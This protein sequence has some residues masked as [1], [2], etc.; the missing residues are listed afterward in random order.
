MRVI[1]FLLVCLAFVVLGGC[2]TQGAKTASGLRATN[3]I[4]SFQQGDLRLHC[5]VACSGA[6]GWSR[7]DLK[8]F[9]RKGL[10]N[11]LV[12]SIAEYGFSVD[13]ASFYLAEAAQQTGYLRAAKVY[14]QLALSPGYRCMGLFNNCDGIDVQRLSQEGLSRLKQIETETAVERTSTSPLAQAPRQAEPPRSTLSLSASAS[15]PDSNGVVTLTITT[16]SDTASL[17]IN[18]D[19]AGGR[20]DGR[21]AVK[22]FA[23]VGENKFEVIATDRFGNTQR[24]TVSVNREFVQAAPSIPALNPL[25]VRAVK[26]RDAVAIVIGI[27]KYRSVSAADFANRDASIFVDYATRALGIPRENIRLL[28][29]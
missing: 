27:E 29:D 11:E 4:E 15:Q 21:Y 6:H 23:Q 19:E 5:G 22:R 13:L 3:Y 17:K 28:L 2:A 25:A 1:L 8:L 16:N 9:Y 14:Y 20:A 18:G 12:S 26:Q 7:K 10:G 24:Q